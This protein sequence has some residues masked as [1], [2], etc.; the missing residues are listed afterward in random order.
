MA[1]TATE[2]AVIT[3]LAPF[4]VRGVAEADFDDI[5]DAWFAQD[6][7]ND[8]PVYSWNDNESSAG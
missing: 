1:L 4:Q 8:N 3:T 7:Y 2:R 5:L 6:H